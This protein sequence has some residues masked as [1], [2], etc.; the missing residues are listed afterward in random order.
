MGEQRVGFSKYGFRCHEEEGDNI[1]GQSR[2]EPEVAEV[3]KSSYFGYG[4]FARN[5]G[6]QV[7]IIPTL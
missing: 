1:V 4:C 7:H 5:T 6:F 2:T 3:F